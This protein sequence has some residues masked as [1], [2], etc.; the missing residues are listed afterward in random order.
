MLTHPGDSE[1]CWPS[2]SP[3]L[4]GKIGAQFTQLQ[5]SNIDSSP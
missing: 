1:T 5:L 4:N 2:G 3:M